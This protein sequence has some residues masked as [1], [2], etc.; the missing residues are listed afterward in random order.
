MPRARAAVLDA[1]GTLFDVGALAAA[2]EAAFP[3]RGEAVN[4]LWR[5]KQLEYS[6]LRTAL[7]RYRDFWEITKDA[8]EYACRTL[9]CALDAATRERIL[10]AYHTIAAM[11]EAHAALARLRDLGVPRYIFS[12][13]TLSMLQA[14]ARSSGLDALLDGYLSVDEEIRQYK[15]SAAAYAFV[16]RQLGL[17]AADV[18]FVSSNFFD[19]A[20]AKNAGL[21]VVW[22]NRTGAP[23]DRL[24]LHPDHVVAD[25]TA[26][27][28]LA[29]G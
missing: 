29:G 11:P 16:L 18:L 26:V 14:A 25:L 27:A 24:G 7:G 20:G 6:W 9:G 10:A 22:V 4:R 2:C 8:L 12:N 5:Q 1:Y 19:V 3:G 13:G 28:A 21:R 15:P 17:P 23:P